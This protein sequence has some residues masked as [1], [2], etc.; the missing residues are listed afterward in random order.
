MISSFPISILAAFGLA[1]ALFEFCDK[2]PISWFTI[3]TTFALSRI[4]LSGL[5][6]CPVC[7]SFWTA[8]ATDGLTRL[9]WDQHYW[10]W[11]LSGFIAVGLTWVIYRE[12]K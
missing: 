1:V 5:F 12:N 7:L 9:M 3:P 10:A 6:D 4:G 11:P 8:L 2:P